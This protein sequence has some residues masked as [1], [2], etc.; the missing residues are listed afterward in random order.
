MV[1]HISV[2][3][4]EDEV[5]HFVLE[6]P[7]LVRFIKTRLDEIHYLVSEI[8]TYERYVEFAVVQLRAEPEVDV[9]RCVVDDLG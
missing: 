6:V 1:L 7:R 8:V 9:Y 5:V 3:I 4:V 2:G